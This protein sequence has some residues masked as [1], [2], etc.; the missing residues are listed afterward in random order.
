VFTTSHHRSLSWARWI[1][2]TPTRPIFLRS[3]VTLSSHLRLGLPSD[4]FPHGTFRNKLVSYRE[5]L[6]A[7]FPTPKLED[8]PLSAVHDCLFNIFSPILYLWRPFPPATTR[9]NSMGWWIITRRNTV[10]VAC[11]LEGP[12]RCTI[13]CHRCDG[14]QVVKPLRCSA[15]LLPR[16]KRLAMARPLSVQ[17]PKTRRVGGGGPFLGATHA[18]DHLI[19]DRQIV[20][21]GRYFSVWT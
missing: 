8:H 6:L 19:S 3:S 1:Q 17:I 5:K 21:M 4:P 15:V 14:P 7:A 9:G 16:T 11:N 10:A 12:T 18:G 2:F 13:H 20:K